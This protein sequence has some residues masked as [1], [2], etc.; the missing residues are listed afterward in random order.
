MVFAERKTAFTHLHIMRGHLFARILTPNVG[1]REVTIVTTE[2][3]DAINE[4][5]ADAKGR[6]FVLDVTDVKM[7]SSMGLGMCVDLKNQADRM[8][9]RSILFGATPALLQLLKLMRVDRLFTVVAD[10]EA[11][12]RVLG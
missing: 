1:P 10:N 8:K 2:I 6:Y 9:M 3:S 12:E 4:L 11:L 5:L 7:L